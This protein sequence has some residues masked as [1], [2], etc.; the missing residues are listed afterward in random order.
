MVSSTG[1]SSPSPAGTRS[2][3]AP[4][5]T[6][7]TGNPQIDQAVADIDAALTRLKAA[8]QSGD[9]VAQGQ[10]LSDL[11]AAANRYEQAKAAAQPPAG[12]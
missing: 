6:P 8:Q 9:F 7:T 10:A 2:G 4:D 11:E 5:A 3:I 12:G 1:P